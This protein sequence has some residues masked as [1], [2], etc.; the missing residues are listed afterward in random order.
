MKI[1]VTPRS[2]TRNHN[3]PALQPLYAAGCEVVFCSPGLSPSE[4]ELIDLLPGCAGY[5]A[6]V[7]KIS[8][9]VLDLA[10]DLKVISRNGTGTDNIDAD[11][12]R[13]NNIQVCRAIGANARGVA[14]LTFGLILGLI[15]SIPFSDATMKTGAWERRQGVEVDGRTIGLVGCG[16]IGRHVAR[17]ALG[18][19][20]QVV[21]YDPFPD[22]GFKPSEHFSYVDMA[23][24]LDQAD[25]ISLHCPALPAGAA[26]VDADMIARMRNG[27][28]LVNTA[29]GSLIDQNAALLAL[30]SG[31][32]AG[33][34]VDAFDPEPPT[35]WRLSKDPR[36]I[37]TPHIGGFTNESIERAMS[38]AV[39]NLLN[40]LAVNG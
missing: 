23:G 31:K 40:A 36:V 29:R 22:P 28:Y 20:M 14:E 8:G 2:V 15:R 34:A 9:K 25:I 26:L 39:D 4:D 5:L 33:I 35:D 24:L 13:R 6:G 17:F 10:P 16:V 18:F 37:S 21:A 3:H 1:L 27:V 38:V 7:E 32:I 12:A 11:S 19:D 30:A